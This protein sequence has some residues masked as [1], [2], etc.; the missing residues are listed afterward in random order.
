MHKFARL[1]RFSPQRRQRAIV[2]LVERALRQDHGGEAVE[3]ALV[4]G[5]IVVGAIAKINCVGSKI[6][7]RWDSLNFEL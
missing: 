7:S 1:M 2:R 3:Y 5:L 6:S 4:V